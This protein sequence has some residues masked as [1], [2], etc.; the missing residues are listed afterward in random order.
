MGKARLVAYTVETR[1]VYRYLVVK[2]EVKRPLG[3]PSRRWEG[4]IRIDFQ[5]IGVRSVNWIIVAQ[6]KK[7]SAIVKMVMK[8][9]VP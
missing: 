3:V 8:Y 5:G 9:W 6:N 4:D 7:C 1:R 2:P